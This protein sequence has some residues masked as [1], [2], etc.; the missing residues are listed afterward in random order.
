MF[1]IACLSQY[2]ALFVVTFYYH[3]YTDAFDSSKAVDG[4]TLL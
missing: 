4:A 1:A 2:I 3:F